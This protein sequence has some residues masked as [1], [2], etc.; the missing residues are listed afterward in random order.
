[1]IKIKTN[2]YLQYY[3]KSEQILHILSFQYFVEVQ[4][5]YQLYVII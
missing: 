1:M 5:D 4:A 2:S 3:M